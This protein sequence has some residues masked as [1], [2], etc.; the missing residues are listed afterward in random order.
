MNSDSENRTRQNL[1]SNSQTHNAI[2][3]DVKSQRIIPHAPIISYT[4]KK[5]RRRRRFSLRRLIIP[6]LC[7]LFASLLLSVYAEIR[8]RPKIRELSIISAK[9]MIAETV[10]DTVGALAEQGLLTYDS[11]V[12]CDRDAEG[13]VNFLEVDT[14]ML[15]MV[16]SMIVKEID[17]ALEKRKKVTVTVPFGSLSGWNIFSGLGLPVGVKV[18]PIGATEGEIYTVLEDC[19]INQTRHLIRVDIKVSMLCVLPEENCTVE[20]EITIPLGER[21][22]VG[23]VP[24]IYLDSIGTG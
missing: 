19:G 24:E 1:A 10:N 8:L 3:N 22:L 17:T 13:N 9:K 21:V 12:T 6:L 20:S 16:R 2:I 23:E 15:S 5:K 7:F 4:G 14:D 11:M 18:H